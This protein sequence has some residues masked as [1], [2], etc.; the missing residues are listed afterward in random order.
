MFAN[1]SL[2]S[3][4]CSLVELLYFPEE[5]PTVASIYE[6]YDI[7]KIHCYHIH[8]HT[9][10]TAIQFIVS[11]VDSTFLE[12]ETRKILFEIFSTANLKERFD[13][14]NEFWQQF[15]I[16]ETNNNVLGLYK[17]ENINNPCLVSIAVNPNEYLELF[18]SETVNKRIE[19]ENF[20]ERIN[21]HMIVKNK[22]SQINDKRFYFPNGIISL[23][24]GHM[25][26]KE[27]DEYKNNKGKRIEENFWNGKE[28]LLKLEK[29]CLAKSERLDFLNTI[30]MQ[31]PKIVNMN[32]TK[33]DRNTNFI[34]SARWKLTEMQAESTTEVSTS[35]IADSMETF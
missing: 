22:F 26:L 32:V 23:P 16:H 2:K 6:K 17:V 15:D 33:F 9:N 10:N 18:K 28:N 4:I 13:N 34:L 14:S 7:E 24:F 30:L 27:V 21:P 12:S 31:V 19:Y 25:Y 11:N 1:R 3:F 8:T 20:A 35:T 29:K 5:N